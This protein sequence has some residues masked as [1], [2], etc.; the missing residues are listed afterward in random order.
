MSSWTRPLYMSERI[1]AA[2]KGL[3]RAL[4]KLESILSKRKVTRVTP[5]GGVHPR[6]KVLISVKPWC[7]W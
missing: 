4:S 6:V 5:R 2:T 1:E 3:S 7:T